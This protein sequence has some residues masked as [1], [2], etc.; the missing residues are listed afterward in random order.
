MV[1]AIVAQPHVVRDFKYC[2]QSKDAARSA[3]SNIAEGFGR[4]RHREFA[5]FLRISMGSLQEVTDLLIDGHERG[6][7]SDQQL[8]EGRRLATRAKSACAGL[9]T[10][11]LQ[12]PDRT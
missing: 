6:Y 9:H 2:N 11:L 12:T 1:F 8:A 4:Y 5:Q 3:A 7:V 10:Y